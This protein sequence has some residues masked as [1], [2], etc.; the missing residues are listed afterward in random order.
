[1]IKVGDT[2]TPKRRSGIGGVVRKIGKDFN[3]RPLY[4]LTSGTMYTEAEIKGGTSKEK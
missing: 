2:I 4:I 1:M 3:G